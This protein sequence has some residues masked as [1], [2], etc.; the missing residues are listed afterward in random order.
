MHFCIGRFFFWQTY[1]TLCNCLPALIVPDG[2]CIVIWLIVSVCVMCSFTLSPLK[3]CLFTFQ[4]VTRMQL[5]MVFLIFLVWVCWASWK[6][7]L[8][9]FSNFEKFL[10][11]VF[12]FVCP[13]LFPLLVVF[14]LPMLDLWMLCNR[15]LTLYSWFYKHSFFLSL[16]KLDDFYWHSCF[17]LK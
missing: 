7:K 17:V 8:M 10:A 15:F 12:F 9:P 11:S 1:R 14:E 13:V 3:S 4:Q 6:F 16:S 2:E 5:D